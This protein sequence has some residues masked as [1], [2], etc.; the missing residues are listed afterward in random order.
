MRARNQGMLFDSC[1]CNRRNCFGETSLRYTKDF[2]V[3]VT[4]RMYVIKFDS[5]LNG[6][7]ADRKKVSS[8]ELHQVASSL[9]TGKNVQGFS[10]NNYNRASGPILG[11]W[12]GGGIW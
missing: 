7:T 3:H 4:V 2:V 5:G 8:F 12:S 11:G 6:N 1:C 9:S 10:K